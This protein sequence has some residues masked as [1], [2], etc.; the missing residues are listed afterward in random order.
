MV[1]ML[2]MLCLPSVFGMLPE[3]NDTSSQRYGDGCGPVSDGQLAKQFLD[4]HLGCFHGNPGVFLAVHS[5]TLV[6]LGV[7]LLDNLDLEALAETA[8]KL[9]RWEFMLTIAPLRAQN[10]AGSAVN[11]VAVF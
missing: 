3:M 11:P 1:F 8:A 7:H 9:K 2:R 6:A 5:F 4:V 10:G